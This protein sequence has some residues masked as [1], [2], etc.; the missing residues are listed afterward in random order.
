MSNDF[1]SPTQPSSP[2][3]YLEKMGVKELITNINN[4]DKNSSSC[5]RKSIAANRKANN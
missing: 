1:I 4:E 3:R 5:S 2:Y